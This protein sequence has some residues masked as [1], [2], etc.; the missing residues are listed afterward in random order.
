MQWSEDTSGIYLPTWWQ[1]PCNISCTISLLVSSYNILRQF[2]NYRNPH[3]QRLVVR[4]LLLVP[5]FSITCLSATLNPAFTKIYLDFIRE[6]YEAFVIY[7]FFSYLT[8]ILG[9]ERKIITELSVGKRPI[10]HVLP[11]IY[12][13]I[14]LSN[15]YSFLSVKRG[16]LQYVWFKPFYCL[17]L[18]VCQVYHW[19][20]VEVW[21]LILYN[22][23][24]TWSLYNLALFWKCLYDELR[25]FH[26]WMKFMCVKLIIFASY[27]QGMIIKFLSMM[28]KLQI[29]GDISDNIENLP[30]MYQNGLLCVE[31]VGFAILHSMAFSWTEYSLQTIP[32]GARMKVW[33]ALRDCFGGGDLIWDFKQTLF[34]GDTYYNFKNFLPTEGDSMTHNNNVQT[35]M[36]RLNKGLRFTNNGQDTYWVNYGSI[37]DGHDFLRQNNR[38]EDGIDDGNNILTKDIEDEEWVDDIFKNN[39]YI[40]E[41]KNYPV[42]W[43]SKAHRYTNQMMSLR[44]EVETRAFNN[45][46]TN[47]TSLV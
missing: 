4:I 36:N 7:T 22:M 37:S 20:R 14:D 18:L 5:I 32:N 35:N 47:N 39:K 30:Y 43:N 29:D 2:M 10:R 46:S 3:E 40:P 9:G 1:W 13:N 6:F 24:V 8:L 27:W 42:E 31:M 12:G 16:V 17:F 26:P 33:Y 15:P 21:L 41:D 19:D 45:N 34:I 25:Q 44:E 28:G 23:S 38:R 11:F